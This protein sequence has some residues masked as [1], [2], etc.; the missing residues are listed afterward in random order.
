MCRDPWLGQSGR[1][2][3]TSQPIS[4]AHAKALLLGKYAPVTRHS[5]FLG[6]DASGAPDAIEGVSWARHEPEPYALVQDRCDEAKVN[7]QTRSDQ[8]WAQSLVG[9]GEDILHDAHN[10]RPTWKTPTARTHATM[11]WTATAPLVHR[12]PNMRFCSAIVAK[13][14]V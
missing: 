13:H 9:V 10:N 11:S 12:S 5:P 1:S 6:R 7:V 8:A 14:G 2:Q 3:P 4:V